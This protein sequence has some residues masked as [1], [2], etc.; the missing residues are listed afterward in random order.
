MSH[1][2]LFDSFIQ[3]F[4]RL[5]VSSHQNNKNV[6]ELHTRHHDEKKAIV[7]TFNSYANNA[8][9][10][11]E[12]HT[13]AL[14]FLRG[15][16]EF[17]INGYAL[18]RTAEQRS[19][20]SAY[21][22]SCLPVIYGKDIYSYHKTEIHEAFGIETHMPIT[23][24]G[25]F[26]QIGKTVGTSMFIARLLY[27]FDDVDVLVIS[28]VQSQANNLLRIVFELFCTL[29]DALSRIV[30]HG[31]DHL[32][33]IN[34]HTKRVSRVTAVGSTVDSAR[35]HSPKIIV[36]DEAAY[37]PQST[38]Q[39][40]IIPIFGNDGVALLCITTHAE[41]SFFEFMQKAVVGGKP[42]AN[43]IILREDADNTQWFKI[44]MFWRTRFRRDIIDALYEGNPETYAREMKG[45]NPSDR[46][47]VFIT[48]EVELAFKTIVPHEQLKLETIF[49]GIDN[50]NGGSTSDDAAVAIG[51]TQDNEL[52]VSPIKP[53][54]KSTLFKWTIHTPV[55]NKRF[56][57]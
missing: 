9:K 45:N 14:K 32:E 50:S 35:G 42:V 6:A 13:N 5:V 34:P 53:E 27:D 56:C 2:K 19:F 1:S 52:A 23:T 48:P 11:D 4:K 17:R 37:V 22:N 33:I 49:I 39:Q 38:Y 24:V 21:F 40:L 3:D 12:A 15:L 26:R 25:A 47:A 16:D 41:E 7:S 54:E 28:Y 55:Q 18:E 8:R 43:N 57:A 31:T 44:P 29:P 10:F 36:V 51:V 46:Q 20:H 30:A